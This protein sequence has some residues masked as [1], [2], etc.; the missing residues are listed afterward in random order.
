MSNFSELPPQSL[1]DARRNSPDWHISQDFWQGMFLGICTSESIE[2]HFSALAPERQER[3][4]DL[5][6]R[7]ERLKE[8][9]RTL[10]D[11][12]DA[13]LEAQVSAATAQEVRS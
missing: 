7:G 4:R 9:F 13:E 12:I 10:H 2:K 11:E 3:F 1:L 6:T 5:F 8:E